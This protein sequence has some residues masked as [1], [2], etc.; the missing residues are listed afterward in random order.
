MAIFRKYNMPLFLKTDFLPNLHGCPELP[1]L[2]VGFSHTE[3]AALFLVTITDFWS[4]SCNQPRSSQ[5]HTPGQINQ[6]AWGLGSMKGSRIILHN[7]SRKQGYTSTED[8]TILWVEEPLLA[9]RTTQK[10]A[11]YIKFTESVS[12][13]IVVCISIVSSREKIRTWY[14]KVKI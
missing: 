9:V 14:G 4:R 13:F 6:D 7:Y 10:V 2:Y 11:K 5:V 1:S 3:T 12:I 8:R